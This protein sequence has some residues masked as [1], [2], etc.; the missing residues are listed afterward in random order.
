[1]QKT[2]VY[3]GKIEEER[4]KGADEAERQIVKLFEAFNSLHNLPKESSAP[5]SVMLQILKYGKTF[6]RIVERV[7]YDIS[8]FDKVLGNILA[9][10]RV[11]DLSK[12][13]YSPKWTEPDVKV[14]KEDV[15]EMFKPM[16]A[17][18]LGDF[19]FKQDLKYNEKFYEAIDTYVEKGKVMGKVVFDESKN[20]LIVMAN[21]VST[22]GVGFYYQMFLLEPSEDKNV[23]KVSFLCTCPWALG[24]TT[25][26]RGKLIPPEFTSLCKHGIAT[27]FY[28]YPEIAT[29]VKLASEGRISKENFEKLLPQVRKA[30]DEV[31]KRVEEYLDR[32]PNARGVV[33]SNVA[34]AVTRELYKKFQEIGLPKKMVPDDHILP[35]FPDLWDSIKVIRKEAVVEE[36][37]FTDKEAVDI[38]PIITKMHELKIYERIS[39]LEEVLNGLQG[40]RI[41]TL[42]TKSLLAG[43]VLGSDLETDPVIVS[44]VGDPGTGKT[45]TAEGLARLIGIRSLVIEK[46]VEESVLK[47]EALEIMRENLK[48]YSSF[49][50]KVIEPR[51]P[52]EKRE[53]ARKFLE[54]YLDKAVNIASERNTKTLIKLSKQF[55]ETF[56]SLY[57]VK[58]RDL[59]LSIAKLF[60]S[61]VKFYR[62]MYES[63][64][65]REALERKALEERR[66]L[67]QLVA[68]YGLISRPEDKEE[69]NSGSVRWEILETARGYKIRVLI[70]LHYALRRFGGD[71]QKLAEAIKEFG[72]EGN[73]YIRTEIPGL[74]E[75]KLSEAEYLEKAL[76]VREEDIL[77]PAKRLIW[78]GGELT[79]KSL[80]LIDESRRAPELL[81]RLLTDLSTA[82]RDTRRTNL[83]VTTDNAE[84]LMEAE[85][86]PRLDAFHSRINFEVVTPSTT[87]AYI[88]SETLRKISELERDGK[89]PLVTFDELLLLNFVSN[90][91]KMPE[92]Y[93]A[94]LYAM[95]LLL[96]YDF[97]ILRPEVV[98]ALMNASV[99]EK[100]NAP[101][102]ILPIPKGAVDAVAE[103][104]GDY[105][106]SIWGK[107]L[108][109]IRMMPERRFGHHVVR[110][111]KALAVIHQ[112]TEVDN[113]TFLNALEMVLMAR[114][115]PAGHRFPY[116]Y[117]D[118]KRR[119]VEAFIDKVRE[120][121]SKPT[122]ATEKLVDVLGSLSIP[123]P[124]TI[125]NALEEMI[126]NPVATAIFVRFVEQML[127]SEHSKEFVEL[128]KNIPGLYK[129]I[130]L[131][132]RYEKIRI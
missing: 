62:K 93:E 30:F 80:I 38:T 60:Y 24:H 103:I 88:I 55:A 107:E 56:A 130:E 36:K 25:D 67:L 106:D 64:V 114:V 37:K 68:S 105:Q 2:I 6:K 73:V 63:Y 40:S 26:K 124:E 59:K 51:L 122:T 127:V 84:P 70:D 89:L 86:D 3:S 13:F 102:L 50:E 8:E 54:E 118:E 33:I 115:I 128:A 19:S 5:S 97:K 96:V 66:K 31:Q 1:M 20:R 76:R 17:L 18:G 44:V 94:V 112:K 120:F 95:P 43:L 104:Q 35:L 12:T 82:A 99:S 49:F 22:Q 119:V 65:S 28:F 121:L 78:V 23:I 32:N 27:L 125:A 4:H 72:K 110:A 34:Y 71:V 16:N 113:E 92:R 52:A 123:S 9:R 42:Y 109:G 132:A 100:M 111:A 48:R 83:I 91:V 77:S 15:E 47:Q 101:P 79:K 7:E 75:L 98:S 126:N 58:D 74:A 10:S 85:S 45:L 41:S 46:D 61:I 131:I 87:V 39:L 117:I 108:P 53:E 14:P 81:E 129:T 57:G 90:N 116:L 29:Y 69:L 21:T 11:I